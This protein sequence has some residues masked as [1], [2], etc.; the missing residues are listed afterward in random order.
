[1]ARFDMLPVHRR[2]ADAK[3]DS[4]SIPVRDEVR[5]ERKS[6]IENVRRTRLT[7]VTSF[8]VTRFVKRHRYCVRNFEPTIRR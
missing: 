3:S 2:D 5:V 8:Y 7:F 4:F 1:M 6:A